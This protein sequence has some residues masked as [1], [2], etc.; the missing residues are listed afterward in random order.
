MYSFGS[1]RAGAP[2][3]NLESIASVIAHGGPDY[4]QWMSAISLGWGGGY[5]GFTSVY[6]IEYSNIKTPVPT[7]Y[8]LN[9]NGAFGCSLYPVHP[10]CST[11]FEGAYYPQ[12]NLASGIKSLDPMW[13]SC[14]D[15][16]QGLYDPPVALT[17]QSAV[18]TPIPAPKPYT[19]PAQPAQHIT[20][21]SVPSSHVNPPVDQAT[22]HH[23]SS[24][25][26][27]P[28]S[29][30]V[31]T[32]TTRGPSTIADPSSAASPSS[33]QGSWDPFHGSSD[34]VTNTVPDTS[35]GASKS[36]S[37]RLSNSSPTYSANE[38]VGSAPS[39]PPATTF[40]PSNDAWNNPT[41]PDPVLNS[42]SVPATSV[43]DAESAGVS[44]ATTSHEEA[45]AISSTDHTAKGTLNALS[46]LS[47]AENSAEDN[48]MLSGAVF[49]AS[50]GQLHTAVDPSG[51][52]VVDNSVTIAEGETATVSSLGN[53]YAGSSG[54][55]VD[56]HFEAYTNLESSGAAPTDG[57][58]APFTIGSEISTATSASVLSLG[59]AVLSAGG[60]AITSAGETASL[61]S[62]GIVVDG[63]TYSFAAE[64][65]APTQAA[66]FT[67]GSSAYTVLGAPGM[68]V[69]G[70]N[71]MTPG[72]VIVESGTTISDASSAL[73]VGT[74]T[75]YLSSVNAAA[76]SWMGAVITDGSAVYTAVELA[77]GAA[78]VD[79]TTLSSG[80]SALTINGHVMSDA[81]SGLVVD[82]TN[83]ALFSDIRPQI[84]S[85]TM[86]TIGS[87]IF[88]A[89]QVPGETGVAE[90]DGMTL[91]VGGPAITI[92]GQLVT[93][94][95]S[96]VVIGGTQTVGLSAAS[97]SEGHSQPTGSANK[98]STTTS[99]AI[100]HSTAALRLEVFAFLLLAFWHC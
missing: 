94:G 41:T 60:P 5:Q 90:V 83:T 18:A 72:Q 24:D 70:H 73:I 100:T 97:R 92:G 1:D 33:E 34:P 45:G 23:S 63:S 76:G 69:F 35:A 98:P 13:S 46:V 39:D 8:Y 64:T 15:A 25:G 37:E 20:T 36:V 55:S 16:V 19:T 86:F 56:G 66:V 9:A 96:G 48:T 57:T 50:N 81:S 10:L 28:S 31:P 91:S 77:D 62:H 88:T 54:L 84:T 4:M 75:I 12:I 42:I 74:S 71:T 38:P 65:P 68:F 2:T 82:G 27:T 47:Q 7:A 85:Q 87:Q 53:V 95:P 26:T 89:V 3:P 43:S 51:N 30:A 78:V 80:G 14:D 52:V 11:I 79:G 49:T 40:V 59:T 58:D 22:T 67:V 21:T 6:P 44:Y 61:A 99:G 32:S 29:N 17:P 93:D